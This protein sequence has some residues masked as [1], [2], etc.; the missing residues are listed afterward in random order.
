VLTAVG[1]V[2]LEPFAAV[3]A[4]EGERLFGGVGE[5]GKRLH[6]LAARL[7]AT[8]RRDAAAGLADDNRGQRAFLDG[9]GCVEE[10]AL[11]LATPRINLSIKS[12][13]C[14]PRNG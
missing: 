12:A 9:V 6:T 7:R 8:G 5:Q 2:V 14:V 10:V 1:A 3:L 13:F 4:A 11:I